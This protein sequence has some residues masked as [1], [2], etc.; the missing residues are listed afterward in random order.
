MA[1]FNNYSQRFCVLPLHCADYPPIA[2]VV[3]GHPVNLITGSADERV[4]GLLREERVILSQGIAHNLAMERPLFENS[5]S[6]RRLKRL[7]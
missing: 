1:D 4:P 2:V 3:I 7:Q 5:I 6:L